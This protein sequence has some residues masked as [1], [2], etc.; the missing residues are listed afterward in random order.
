MKS[1]S[2]IPGSLSL[3]LPFWGRPMLTEASPPNLKKPLGQQPFP[4]AFRT[5]EIQTRS[6]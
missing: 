2:A 1:A 4:A 6:L 5:V 3:F